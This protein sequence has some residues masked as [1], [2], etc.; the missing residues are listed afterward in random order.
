MNWGKY[1]IIGLASFMLFIVSA[2][3]YMVTQDSDSLIDENYYENSL[4]YNDVYNSKQNL[5][6]DEA[7]PTLS[8][9]NDTLIVGFVGTDNKGSFIFKRPSDGTLDKSIPFATKEGEFRLPIS[10][11]AK[12]NWNVEITWKQRGVSY[13]H[14]QA[15]FIQ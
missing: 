1:I 11:F 10:T 3:L 12:G 2:G 8:L 15:L 4:T 5:L 13:I 14:N 9:R 6:R 7:T